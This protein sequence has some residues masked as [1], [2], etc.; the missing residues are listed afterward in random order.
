MKDDRT[1]LRASFI[2]YPSSFILHFYFPSE[3]IAV[4]SILVSR[5]ISL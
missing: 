3:I 1:W 4:D 2:L 5:V